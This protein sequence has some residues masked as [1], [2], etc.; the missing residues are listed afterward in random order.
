MIATAGAL[1]PATSFQVMGTVQVR[2]PVQ[3]PGLAGPG[4]G[5]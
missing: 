5:G 2:G 3:V 1:A 4:Q